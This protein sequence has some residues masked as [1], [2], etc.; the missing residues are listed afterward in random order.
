M[1]EGLNTEETR[2][3]LG[4]PLALSVVSDVGRVRGNNEDAWGTRWLDD[5]SLLVVVCDGMG[6]HE[7]GEVA[8]G[9]A[10]EVIG[11]TIAQSLEREPQAAMYTALLDANEAIVREGRQT[12]K[13]GMG[14]TAVLARLLGDEVHVGLVGDSRLYHVRGGRVI[15]R[16]LDHTRVQS[17]LER[18]LIT[19]EEAWDHPD[20]GKLTRAL[21]HRKMSD[22][23]PLEPEVFATPL[24]LEEGDALV[25]STDGLHDLVHDHEIA[26]VVA[27]ETPDGACR[28]LV[29]LALDRGGHDNITVA[30]VVVGERAG[31]VAVGDLTDPVGVAPVLRSAPE[32]AV[33]PPDPDAAE[34]ETR[35]DLPRLSPPAPAPT[36]RWVYGAFALA[37]LLFL[38]AA[39]LLA[40]ALLGA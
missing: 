24:H 19:A 35:D 26:V 37:G 5:G 32:A 6:G 11:E 2:L 8:S 23:T 34:L 22:G 40:T 10:V 12:G 28:T 1:H 25:L 21:G 20:A 33:P 7:A 17:L 3:C 38:A 39:A 30:V 18:G 29:D 9:L 27:G 31:E 36:P 15:D 14:T 13:R 16:T 4:V